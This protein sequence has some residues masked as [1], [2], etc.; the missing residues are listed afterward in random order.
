MRTTE[1]P[2]VR[3]YLPTYVYLFIGY[4]SIQDEH[5]QSVNLIKFP[6]LI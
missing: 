2:T 3:Q 6:I 5:Y 1:Y 4:K